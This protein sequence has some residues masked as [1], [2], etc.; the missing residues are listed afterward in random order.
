MARTAPLPRRRKHEE[1]EKG[2]GGTKD[3][4]VL[5]VLECPAEYQP[6]HTRCCRLQTPQE[7]LAILLQSRL[8]C[9]HRNSIMRSEC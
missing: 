3:A 2:C 4:A 6:R 1:K 5:H 7:R 8:G 9:V